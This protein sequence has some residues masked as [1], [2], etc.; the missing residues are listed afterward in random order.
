MVTYLQGKCT[1]PSSG[2]TSL[3][4]GLHLSYLYLNACLLLELHDFNKS[5]NGK[6]SSGTVSSNNELSDKRIPLFSS[7]K[8][9]NH[10]ILT[11]LL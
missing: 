3:V 1:R 8:M 5:I 6:L 4:L 9:K 10:N 11:Y 7:V 2:S